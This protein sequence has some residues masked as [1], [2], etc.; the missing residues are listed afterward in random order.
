MPAKGFGGIGVF[1]GKG[2]REI[3]IPISICQI[4][5]V[6]LFTRFNLAFHEGMKGFREEGSAILTAL[7]G[8][9]I[10]QLAFKIKIADAQAD[11]F[12]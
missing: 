3:N 7:G 10:N 12:H 5:L 1:A 11:T 4:L 8:S 6:K 2:A 9:N